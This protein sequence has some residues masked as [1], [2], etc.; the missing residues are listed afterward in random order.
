M[1]SG[2]VARPAPAAGGPRVAE[3]FPPGRG[4]TVA[5]EVPNYVPVTDEM[6]RNP[7]GRLADGAAQLPG[8]ELQPAHADHAGQRRTLRL[9]WVWAMNEGGASE[10]TPSC[11]TASYLVNTGNIVQALDGR[12]GELIWEHRVG[13]EATSGQGAMRNMAIYEDKLFVATTDA[14]LVALDARTGK[15]VWESPSPIGKRASRTPAARSSSRASLQGLD[16][17]ERFGRTAAS[18]ARSTPRPASALEV[19]HRRAAAAERRHVGQRRDPFRAGGET[20]ITGSYDPDLNLDLLGRGAGQAVGAG[21]PR[22]DGADK[23]LYTSSTLALNPERQARVVL[24]ALRRAKRSISTK[25]SSACWST[26]AA[27][28]RVHDR[29]AGHSLEARSRD[30]PVPRR[31]RKPSSRTSSTASIRRPACRAIAPDIIEAKIGQWVAACPST[32]GGHNW[33]AMS[34]H[35]GTD[36]LDHPARQTC[37]EISGRQVEF[38]EGSGGTAGDRSSS[39]C[40]APTATSASSRPTT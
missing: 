9:A 16:G 6:L 32:E 38:K 36:L 40:P 33:Q 2:G 21:E 4:L 27:Q 20:W 35:P 18:S 19:Q 17:C 30:R 15:K 39:R 1:A 28:A 29:Q 14:R 8:L 23:A 11:T 24:P 26:S 3:Q 10:P 37:M 12:T 34:Y 5:G 13:P 31:T 25:S 7:P 22:H